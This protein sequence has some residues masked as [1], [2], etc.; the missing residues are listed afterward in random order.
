ME[1]Q[2]STNIGVQN[3]GSKIKNNHEEKHSSK[4]QIPE[5]PTVLEQSVRT[6]MKPTSVFLV[7]L[8]YDGHSLRLIHSSSLV[9]VFC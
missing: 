8:K 3:V 1:G 9:I 5:K 4:V 7:T 2:E 6:S